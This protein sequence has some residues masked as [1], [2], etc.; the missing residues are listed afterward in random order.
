MITNV[1]SLVPNVDEV[2]EFLNRSDISIPCIYYRNLAKTSFCGF[3][4]RFTR[5]YCFKERPN[6]R[7]SWWGMSLP[8]EKLF[9]V[10]RIAKSDIL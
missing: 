6:I 9:D 1:R 10:Y 3:C 7:Q 2:R 5:I 8:R 4:Y